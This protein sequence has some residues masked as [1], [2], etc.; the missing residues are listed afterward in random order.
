MPPREM[1]QDFKN[2]D[3]L[4]K[5]RK[6]LGDSRIEEFRGNGKRMDENGGKTKK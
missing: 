6:K 3:D 4:S 5:N 1:G 2:L